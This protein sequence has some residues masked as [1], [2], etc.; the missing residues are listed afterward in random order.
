[1]GQC[2]D[3]TRR[4]CEWWHHNSGYSAG[5]NT[6]FS[7]RNIASMRIS[8]RTGMRIITTLER[9]YVSGSL[10]PR[11]GRLPPKNG[12]IGKGIWPFVA[13]RRTNRVIRTSS[14]RQHLW[15]PITLDQ[16]GRLISDAN[17]R[18][19]Q[20]FCRGRFSVQLLLP[21]NRQPIGQRK[22]E[23]VSSGLASDYG[24]CSTATVCAARS[25][26]SSNRLAVSASDD[27]HPSCYRRCR[28][29]WRSVA[30]WVCSHLPYPALCA[31]SR[32]LPGV[33]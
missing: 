6:L 21:V 31:C 28:L 15:F 24:R 25:L 11:Y 14:Y 9:D 27:H 16:T 5:E 29:Y 23:I 30:S 18:L 13:Q 32:P 12:A 26:V 33:L 4:S 3:R 8:E 20:D 10:Q 1:V 7:S 17:K 19:V 22:L 2:T